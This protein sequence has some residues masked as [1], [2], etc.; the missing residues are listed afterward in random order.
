MVDD[1]RLLGWADAGR[2]DG[3]TLI[4]DADVQPFLVTLRPDSSLRE[5]L[6]TLVASPTRVAV[7]LD[8]QDRYQGVLDV[9][10]IG[11]ELG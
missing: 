3:L 9:G 7:V 4:A 8:E 11:G 10:R 1:G 6:D 2:L 5:A